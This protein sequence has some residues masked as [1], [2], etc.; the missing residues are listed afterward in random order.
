[1]GHSGLGKPR[2]GDLGAEFRSF[3]QVEPTGECI[4][5]T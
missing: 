4:A 1:M 5:A 2:I 3:E